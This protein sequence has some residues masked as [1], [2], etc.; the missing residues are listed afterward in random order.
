MIRCRPAAW[1]V[2]VRCVFY[3]RTPVGGDGDDDDDI[4]DVVDNDNDDHE[5]DHYNSGKNACVGN[6]CPSD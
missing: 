2:D 4:V 1:S 5:H 6:N 3:V